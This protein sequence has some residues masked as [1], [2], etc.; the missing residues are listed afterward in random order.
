[1]A[2]TKIKI[3]I[4]ED[5]L[6]I[7]QMYRF[8]FESEGYQVETASDG[9][10][11][12]ELIKAFQPDIILMDLMMPNMTGLEVLQRLRANPDTKTV[13]VVV[14]TNNGDTETAKQL[15]QLDV[16]DYIIKA[17]LTPK[18]VAERVTKILQA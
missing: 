1:M 7:V 8:K 15:R 17:D 18:Q 2:N 3:A 13:R 5:E 12:L 14:L 10:T 16:T 9:V 11:G 6:P 4:I